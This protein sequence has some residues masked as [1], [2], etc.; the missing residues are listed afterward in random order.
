MRKFLLPIIN[1]VNLILVSITWGLSNNTAVTDAGAKNAAKGTFYDVIW[2]GEKP[3]ALA[4]VGFFLFIFACVAVLAAFIPTKARKFVTCA[5]SA[6]LIASGVIFLLSPREKFYDCSILEP[7]LTGSL[8]AMAVLVFI[9]GAF[10]ACM[11]LIEFLGKKE[12]K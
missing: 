4:I 8:I 10:M 7:E 6:M 12:S 3:N 11:S 5:G 9:A 1:L 2:T